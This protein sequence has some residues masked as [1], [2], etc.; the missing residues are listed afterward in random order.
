MPSIVKASATPGCTE[1]AQASQNLYLLVCKTHQTLYRPLPIRWLLVSHPPPA[2]LLSCRML[3]HHLL[4]P[5][6]EDHV[7]LKCDSALRVTVKNYPQA[8][9]FNYFALIKVIEQ[10]LWIKKW[11]RKAIW[12][13][14]V[15]QWLIMV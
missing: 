4:Y 1:V 10:R 2:S 12:T 15:H 8:A 11:E 5:C 7:M 6:S 13:R 9:I 3:S 14:S